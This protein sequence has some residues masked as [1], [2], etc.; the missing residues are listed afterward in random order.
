MACSENGSPLLELAKI[1]SYYY[2][3]IYLYIAGLPH[4]KNTSQ[5]FQPFSRHR[6]EDLRGPGEDP[7]ASEAAP[8]L[9]LLEGLLRRRQDG[10]DASIQAW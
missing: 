8:G 5:K 2:I 10:I 1:T 7:A 3:Y 4:R 9:A 6:A